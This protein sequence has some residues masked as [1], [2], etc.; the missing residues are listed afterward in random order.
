MSAK[1]VVRDALLHLCSGRVY[2]VTVPPVAAMPLII[3]Q[4]VGGVPRSY[5]E[6]ALPDLKNSRI[7]T[8]V[9]ARSIAEA[10]AIADQVATALVEAIGATPLDRPADEYDEDTA[11]YGV[12]QD[13]SVW[14][15]D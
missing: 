1:S 15:R 11:L 4:S 10:D 8:N 13:F 7:Q 14:I 9:W 6:N 12:R 3:L 5:L 2:A